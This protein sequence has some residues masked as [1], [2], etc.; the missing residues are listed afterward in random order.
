M[1]GFKSHNKWK[2]SKGELLI[3]NF[4]KVTHL[5]NRVV[6]GEGDNQEDVLLSLAEYS[7]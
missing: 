2:G 7:N 4:L 3:H 5:M 6:L 1:G